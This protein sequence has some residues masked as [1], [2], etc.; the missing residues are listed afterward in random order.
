MIVLIPGNVL[1]LPGKM[2]IRSFCLAK[3]RE[4]VSLPHGFHNKAD[5]HEEEV[6]IRQP[7]GTH[8]A[9][10]YENVPFYRHK[11]FV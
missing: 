6:K 11:L 5:Q 4:M 7:D 9:A 1:T 3:S 2:V 8:L 10:S